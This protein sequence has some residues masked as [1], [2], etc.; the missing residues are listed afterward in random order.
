MTLMLNQT[1]LFVVVA[2]VMLTDGIP[3]PSL[4]SI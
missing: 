3:E 1:G 4:A 2:Q